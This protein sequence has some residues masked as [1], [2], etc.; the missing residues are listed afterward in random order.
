MIKVIGML[1]ACFTA[2]AQPVAAQEAF[3]GKPIRIVVPYTPGGPTDTVARVVGRSVSTQFGQPVIVENKPGAASTIGTN[4]VVHQPADGYTLVLVAAHVVTNSA[5]GMQMPYD[6]LKDLTPIGALTWMPI[7]VAANPSVPAKDLKSLIDWIRKQDKPV[8]Y[9]SPGEGTMTQFWGEMFAQRN[10]LSLQHVPYKG[11]AEAARAAV[12]GD[13][14]LLFDV[15]GI[16]ATMIAQGKLTGIVTPGSQRAPGLPNLQTARE[17]GVPDMEA[18]SFLGLMGPANLPVAVRDKL[19]A[20]VNRAL[21]DPEVVAAVSGLG[22]TPAGG[23]PDEFGKLLAS[24]LK[25]WTEVGRV[26]GIKASN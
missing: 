16:T 9:A 24:E 20:A 25:R 17:A 6:P 18:N 3:P 21:K 12:G 2:F 5:M 23:T 13:V 7:L 19:N 8:Q 22:L 15:A 1:L 10:K 26:A 14:P 4:Y 11:S